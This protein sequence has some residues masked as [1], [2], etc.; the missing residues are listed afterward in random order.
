MRHQEFSRDARA[1]DIRG[2]M[3][4]LILKEPSVYQGC[5]VGGLRPEHAVLA[6]LGALPTPSGDS[7]SRRLVMIRLQK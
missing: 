4:E 2:L 6:P 7:K 1:M 3:A 5:F